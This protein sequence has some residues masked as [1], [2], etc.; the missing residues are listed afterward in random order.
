MR[1]VLAAIAAVAIATTAAVPPFE[2]DAQKPPWFVVESALPFNA[3]Q[4]AT[5]MWG[6]HAGAGYRIEVPANWNGHLV[7]Y[8]HGYRGT[9]P[10]LTVSN[11][12]IRAH[13]IAQGYAWAAS[14]FRANGYVPGIG[15]LDT[16][17][18][19]EKFA[20][21]VG[22]PDLVY[23][24]G[25]SMGGHVTGAAIEQ[26]PDDFDGAQP[27]CGV[28]GDNE[29]FDY[30]QDAYLLAETLAGNEPEVPTPS[31]YFTSADGWPATRVALGP[32]FPVVLNAAGERY[33]S[34]IEN[35]T[36]GD[37]PTY[38][39]G[40]R[41]GTGGAFIFNFGSA[42]TGGGRSNIDTVYQF[43]A[44]PALTAEEQAF[45]DEIVRIEGPPQFLHPDGMG[46]APGLD[47]NSPRING[48]ISIPVIST[49]TLGE[50][51]VPFHMEQIYA[52]RVAEHGKSD[53]L[54]TRA[55]RDI[56]HCAFSSAERIRAF[57]D[58]RAWVEDGVVPAGD[59]VLDP[60]TVADPA[61]G[62]QFTTPDRG[63]W[64]KCSD[65]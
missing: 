56:G 19:L 64:P 18:L 5:A 59:D 57:D 23:M 1:R 44:D 47:A 41:G 52:Q 35:L 40:F 24:T 58:L 8:A 48:D 7:M 53:L 36:G 15:A 17:R 54:V 21:L 32:N 11:P 29:L 62:C 31:D 33:K 3:I 37:R 34:I 4:G 30:F 55:I 60:A 26:W 27:E 61:F 9:G 16:H 2:G 22:E 28:M 46:V 65:L 10:Q 42:T 12:P 13:L 6:V 39:E 45:N 38:D 51:F 63:T 49:H 50:L 14:S 43:D 25:T 20:D